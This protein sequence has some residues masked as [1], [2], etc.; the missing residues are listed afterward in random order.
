MGKQFLEQEERLKAFSDTSDELL[1]EG[2]AT[3]Y[4]WETPNAKLDCLFIGIE[5]RNLDKNNPDKMTECAIVRDING[6]QYLMAQKLIV[7]ELRKKWDETGETGFP[8]RIIYM[9]LVKPGTPDQYQSFRLLY[10]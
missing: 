3:Y 2:T 5:G 7:N 10:E 8:V 1:N 4:K 6:N 9:G